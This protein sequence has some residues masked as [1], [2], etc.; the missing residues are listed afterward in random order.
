[1][2]RDKDK[3]HEEEWAGNWNRREA[4]AAAEAAAALGGGDAS[5]IPMKG[6]GHRRSAD[7]ATRLSKMIL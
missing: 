5:S 6:G 7:L 1:M 3:V 2:L 4:A